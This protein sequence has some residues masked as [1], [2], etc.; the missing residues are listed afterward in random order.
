MVDLAFGL[1]TANFFDIVTI[2]VASCPDT[3]HMSAL[4]H[5]TFFTYIKGIEPSVNSEETINDSHHH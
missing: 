5:N 2:P 1:L 4:S 3:A